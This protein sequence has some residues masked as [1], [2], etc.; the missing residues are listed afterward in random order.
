M[1]TNCTPLMV[2]LFLF[3]YKRDFILFCFIYIIMF[4]SLVVLDVVLFIV[5]LVIY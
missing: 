5:I 4:G 3:D 2:D 1:G